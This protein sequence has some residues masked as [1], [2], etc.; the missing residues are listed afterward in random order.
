M[1]LWSY[2]VMELWSCGVVGFWG[3]VKLKGFSLRSL[4]SFPFPNIFK[5][6]IIFY[7]MLRQVENIYLLGTAHVSEESENQVIEFI[8]KYKP[9]VVAIELDYGRLKTLFSKEKQ[10]PGMFSMIK[11]VGIGGYIFAKIGSLM[12]QKVGKQFNM[13]PGIDMKTA[14]QE[15]RKNK[16]TTALI[17]QNIATTL[18]KFSGISFFK[19]MKIFFN[20]FFKS[21]SK[22]Y[23]NRF[24]IDLKKGIPEEKELFKILSFMKKEALELYQILIE[25][26]N[27]FMAEKLIKLRENHKGPIL[28]VV[29]AGHIPGMYHIIKNKLT[30]NKI[31]FSVVVEI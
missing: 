11:R 3:C 13:E 1:E 31:E 10:K 7:I 26:R 22:K 19:K 29:G 18:R 2:G 9:E 8:D 20:L 27:I 28:A 23:R 6:Q 14:Y 24:N 17:D 12:Q 4:R 5:L 30:P 21:F 25:D 15:A 16:I